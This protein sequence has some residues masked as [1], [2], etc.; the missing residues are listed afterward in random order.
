MAKKSTLSERGKF[1]IE[2]TAALYKNKDIR[3]M[4]CGDTTGKTTSEITCFIPSMHQRR[5]GIL[6]MISYRRGESVNT[7]AVR[8]M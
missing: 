5:N 1:K 6:R 4:I 8:I 2:I 3:E 7:A